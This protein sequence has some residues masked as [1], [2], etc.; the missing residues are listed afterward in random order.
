MS[1]QLRLLLAG[2]ILFFSSCENNSSEKSQSTKV[3]KTI[4][5]LAKSSFAGTETCKG[6]HE[7]EY[8]KWQGSHHHLAMQKADSSTVLAT[9]NTTVNFNGVKST[10]YQDSGKFF[11]RTADQYGKEQDFEI[12]YT[13]GVTPLQ[14]YIVELPKGSY[15]CLQTAW[16]S[17]KKKWFD[18]QPNLD[19]EPG[20]WMHWTGN[21]MKWN[22]ACA[23]CHSTNVHKKFNPSKELYKTSF[24]EITVGCEACHG[25]GSEHVN[26][27]KNK[28]K[29]TPPALYMQKG[30]SSQELVQ[31]CA[32]CHSRRSQITEFFNYDGH[33]L[34]HYDPQLLTIPTYEADGQILDEDYVYASFKQSKMYANGVACN[35]CHDM[36]SMK[37]KQTG[38]NLCMSCHEPKYNTENHYFHSTGTDAAQCINCHMTGRTYMG[39]DFRRDHSFRIPRPDQSVKFGTPNACN[40]CHSDK[41]ASWAANIIE[42]KFGPVRAD[43]FS[44]HLIKGANGE[45]TELLYLLEHPEYPEIARATA[46]SYLTSQIEPSDIDNIKKYLEDKSPLVRNESVK[47]LSNL[48]VPEASSLIEPL[49][50]DEFRVVR[51][52][53]AEALNRNNQTNNNSTAFTKANEEYMQSLKFNADFP[54]GQQRIASYYEAKGMISKAIA[55]YRKALEI[56]NYYNF[57][58]MNL[59]QLLYGQGN[60]NEAESLYR[61]VTEQE[62]EAAYAYYIL[63]LL[64]NENGQ[65]EKSLKHLELAT[66]KEPF[67]PRAF[68]NYSL[69]LHQNGLFEQSIQI[70]NKSL[71]Q[72]PNQEDIT[73]IKLLNEI[74]LNELNAAK[75]TAK[76]LIKI[77]G[78]NPQYIKILEGLEQNQ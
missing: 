49:L 55:A 38:N 14:Q 10:F 63:G 30:M 51:I 53:A 46:M 39:N 75:A 18:L 60:I 56:D 21:A 67:L 73:Y 2:L 52:S 36:H 35:D 5:A 6:C 78:G 54:G 12:I 59:A 42:E 72:N 19:I 11:V 8:N 1:L 48:P 26:F 45:K 66:Q 70:A 33:F 50:N 43:H 77:S 68:Y 40:G 69:M 22:T 34:D 76:N 9:F 28:K 27:Y 57:A 20:E 32:R 13:F 15:Q 61:K 62:P 29:G 25:P 41:S 24:S 23:D 71:T 3:L 31:K 65:Q 47:A 74:K 44:D 16:D 7:T 4:P 64:Y 17:K 58:R 37:L